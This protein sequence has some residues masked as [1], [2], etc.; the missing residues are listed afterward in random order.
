MIVGS[1]KRENKAT[2]VG[3]KKFKL[4]FI[5]LARG[6]LESKIDEWK[7]FSLLLFYSIHV[8]YELLAFLRVIRKSAVFHENIFLLHTIAAVRAINLPVKRESTLCGDGFTGEKKWQKEV[9]KSLKNVICKSIP[10]HTSNIINQRCVF[11]FLLRSLQTL[12][13]H[14]RVR[15]ILN[16][17]Y[18]HIFVSIRI[19]FDD[20][21]RNFFSN[22]YI[23]RK[24]YLSEWN[25][26]S[27]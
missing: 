20:G 5:R 6:A 12:S 25:L 17:K 26:K 7:A 13:I 8:I 19:I 11:F 9:L 16:F 27:I 14:P 18:W 3:R 2:R 23:C 15:Y 24:F 22:L 21:L 1:W 10:I 4:L